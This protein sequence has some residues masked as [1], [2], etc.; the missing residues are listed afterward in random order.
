[1]TAIPAR[2]VSI[3]RIR[4][5]LTGVSNE[6]HDI[7][8]QRKVLIEVLANDLRS[9]GIRIQ[10]LSKKGTHRSP[11][12]IARD[13]Q[14]LITPMESVCMRLQADP[15]KQRE[16]VLSAVNFINQVA[17]IVLIPVLKVGQGRKPV[18]RTTEELCEDL[19]YAS[20]ILKHLFANQKMRER[21]IHTLENE[22]A[23]AEKQYQ[24]MKSQ[25]ES[26][27]S[28]PFGPSFSETY[29]EE[30]R[31]DNLMSDYMQAKMHEGY[32]KLAGTMVGKHKEVYEIPVTQPYIEVQKGSGPVAPLG[33]CG[34][35][36]PVP[37]GCCSGA[38]QDEAVFC[39]LLNEV[40]N[41]ILDKKHVLP[42]AHMSLESLSIS[43]IETCSMIF[44]FDGDIDVKVNEL[45]KVYRD[46]VGQIVQ[47]DQ[48]LLQV[49]RLTNILYKTIALALLA[50]EHTLV[51]EGD[52]KVYASVAK[53]VDE[54]VGKKDI[55]FISRKIVM[56]IVYLLIT[57]A[58]PNYR[59]SIEIES[60]A[61]I[62]I[63]D[64]IK[65]FGKEIQYNTTRL[66]DK[67]RKTMIS[68]IIKNTISY[69]SCGK[70]DYS[71]NKVLQFC[72]AE[73]ID[74]ESVRS[75]V[76]QNAHQLGQ[77]CEFKLFDSYCIYFPNAFDMI[78]DQKPF[79]YE[80]FVSELVKTR[81]YNL[82][83]I[84]IKQAR[85]LSTMIE[86]AIVKNILKTMMTKIALVT[87]QFAY[88]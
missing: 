56:A 81:G 11:Q 23:Y 62:T 48:Y 13:I 26:G 31:H 36:A 25:L 44:K 17:P 20:D 71:I 46:I 39:K 65:Q 28:G 83:D 61:L 79:N 50:K 12:K 87:P 32:N 76:S 64:F 1:M 3:N 85:N 35:G 80:T 53:Y 51:Y 2:P 33:C 5:A 45:L 74:L 4:H 22:R 34:A 29:R 57:D 18:P 14:K 69:C 38:G 73:N 67:D 41:M 43:N 6:T 70:L 7:S 9:M 72:H 58:T 77:I 37:V 55:T 30:M 59:R 15:K 54:L 88:K 86:C 84:S 75:E 47:G 63:D 42:L 68:H 49:S 16:Q 24:T 52:E 27:D 8:E 78:V 21:Y 19:Y 66:D 10:I 40:V 60:E 82:K